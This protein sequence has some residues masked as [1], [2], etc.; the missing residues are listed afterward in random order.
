MNRFYLLLFFL[1]S[2]Y[3]DEMS[4]YELNKLTNG[5][6]KK[7]VLVNKNELNQY[8]KDEPK[9]LTKTM[10]AGPIQE[11]IMTQSNSVST[12]PQIESKS[13]NKVENVKK[14]TE[15]KIVEVKKQTLIIDSFD[16]YVKN[17]DNKDK[18]IKLNLK[19]LLLSTKYVFEKNIHTLH[20]PLLKGYLLEEGKKNQNL[21][22]D[23]FEEAV[24]NMNIKTANELLTVIKGL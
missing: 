12:P 16:K 10:K 7:I 6:N 13:I 8:I 17:I 9:D 18:E 23:F 20:Y 3:A 5:E 21:D 24:N 15:E 11:I 4:L 2:L 14:D 19:D 1:S 22:F